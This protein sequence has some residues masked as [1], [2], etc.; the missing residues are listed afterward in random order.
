MNI[1]IRGGKVRTILKT[2][3]MISCILMIAGFASAEDTQDCNWAGN[4]TVDLI[5]GQ[6]TDIG[7]VTAEIVG[8]NLI[9]TYNAEDGFLLYE[10]HLNVSVVPI[11]DSTPG[12]FPFK[13]DELG[14]VT[15]DVY[16][17]PLSTFGLS[18][19]CVE[20]DECNEYLYIASHA[21]VSDGETAW[22]QGMEIDDNTGNWAM[23]FGLPITCECGDGDTQE[24]I[25][26]FPTVALPIAA[27]LG[28]AF[29][30]QR[31]KE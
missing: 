16:V 13:H 31:R 25:P 5:A 17:I 29:F 19:P 26:E 11:G 1:P 20:C 4:I 6:Y 18:N 7:S 3:I 28:L 22:G 12:Q 27:I 14:G 21:A 9:V 2:A 24:E 8:D 10:T 15:T 23:Y 30:F